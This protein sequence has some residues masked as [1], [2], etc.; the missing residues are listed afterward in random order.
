MYLQISAYSLS[1]IQSKEWHLVLNR[2]SLLFILIPL[3]ASSLISARSFITYWRKPKWNALIYFPFIWNGYH[4]IKISFFLM[5]ALVINIGIFSPFIIQ[6][7]WAYI[8][9]MWFVAFLFAI[10]N[11]LLEEVIWRGV[12][13]SRFSEALGEKWALA[14]TSVG[15]GLQHYSLGFPWLVCIA[16]SIGGIFFGGITVRSKSIAPAIFWHFILNLLMI[17]SGLVLR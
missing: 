13:L 7:G 8:Q 4:R 10:T 12:L 3:F 11:S 14:L 1:G 17:F 6:N 2:L 5:I 16:F 15:F 9:E